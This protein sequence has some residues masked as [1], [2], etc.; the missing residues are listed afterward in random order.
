M[1]NERKCETRQKRNEN[2][3]IKNVDSLKRNKNVH[4]K[5]NWKTE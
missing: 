5:E 4:E 1:L 3:Q 2:G